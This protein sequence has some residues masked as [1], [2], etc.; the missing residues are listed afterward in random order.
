MTDGDTGGQHGRGAVHRLADVS[1]DMA[2]TTR[3]AIRASQA[4]AAVVRALDSSSTEIGAV[5]QLIAAIAKQTNVLALNATIEAARA[6]AAGY[7]FAV[8]AG[9]VEN[10][11]NETAAATDEIG[12]RVGGIR[13]DTQDAVSAIEQLRGLIEELDRCQRAIGEIVSAQQAT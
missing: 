7:G 8:V 2:A 11:A 10:L 12:G 5:V 4:A 6:G 9:E 13:A 3:Q 1:S